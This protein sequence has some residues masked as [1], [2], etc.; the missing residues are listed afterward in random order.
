M[1][2][3]IKLVVALPLISV[4]GIPTTL[5]HKEHDD[6]MLE[7]IQ[8]R[9]A[10]MI[11]RS[12]NAGPLFAMAKGERDYDAELASSLARNLAAEAAMDHQSMYLEG[13]DS[14]SY[15][16]NSRS[17]PKVWSTYPAIEDSRVQYREAV[18][19]LAAQA[20]NGLDALR[21]SIGGVGKSCKGCHEDFRTE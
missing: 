13:S 15:P 9:H 4:Q 21:A 12:W 19:N 10:V 6:P 20:G 18:E 16:D 3:I 11:V 5:A 14:E 2:K 8:A 1:N 7:A 17:L